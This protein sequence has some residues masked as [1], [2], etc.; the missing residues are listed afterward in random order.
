MYCKNKTPLEL[1]PSLLSLSEFAHV[2]HS[3]NISDTYSPC[4]AMVGATYCIWPHAYVVLQLV[5][6]Y[7]V[8]CIYA[9]ITQ[10]CNSVT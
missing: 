8:S 1:H 5:C 10:V 9:A 2:C 4:V 3:G 7:T 6:T